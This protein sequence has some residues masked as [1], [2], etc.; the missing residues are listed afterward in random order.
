MLPKG[1]IFLVFFEG[2]RWNTVIDHLV[3]LILGVVGGC[4][5]GRLEIF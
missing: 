5:L 1:F 3:N 2:G 4:I